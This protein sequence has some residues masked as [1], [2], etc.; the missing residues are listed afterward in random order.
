MI[1]TGQEEMIATVMA[2]QENT[3]AATNSIR[4]ELEET[5]VGWRASWHLSTT[6]QGLRDQ[7]YVEIEETRRT[8]ER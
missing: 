8:Y 6:Y 1:K 3:E 2:G 5:T 7:F 4:S